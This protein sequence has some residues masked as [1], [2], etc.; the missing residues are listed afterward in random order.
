MK[1]FKF[2]GED[3]IL[4]FDFLSRLVEE[5]DVL[6]KKEG[7]IMVCLSHI[8]TKTADLEYS[9]LSIRYLSGGLSSTSESVQYFL[10]TY[11][12]ESVLGEATDT[13]ESLKQMSNRT[14]N[15]FESRLGNSA[16][17]CW[18][19]HTD[20]EKIQIFVRGSFPVVQPIVARCLSDSYC[21][22]RKKT[23]VFYIPGGQTSA[24]TFTC[25][26]CHT[27]DAQKPATDETPCF[28]FEANEAIVNMR[29]LLCLERRR[30][31]RSFPSGRHKKF[32]LKRQPTLMAFSL[33]TIYQNKKTPNSFSYWTA[34][35]NNNDRR[36]TR[37]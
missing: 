22:F 13:L 30:K 5:A 20:P 19:V 17:R 21:A 34:T 23:A 16:Y 18:N 8:L 6:Y 1:Y 25:N 7:Q 28:I 9:L 31:R 15:E 33:P 35:I 36:C 32:K 4:I 27:H 29:H 10:S 24:G 26:Q 2:Y 3:P 14:K 37:K 11:A 12:T